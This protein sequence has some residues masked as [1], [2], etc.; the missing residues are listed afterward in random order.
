[1]YAAH[2]KLIAAV[3][4][5]TTVTIAGED[6]AKAEA[7]D[8]V[9]T[10]CSD[11]ASFSGETIEF[12]KGRFRHW[13]Y[14]DVIVAGAK[15]PKYPLEGEYKVEGKKLILSNDE[16]YTKEWTIDTVNGHNVLWRDDGLKLWNEEKRIH[17]YAVL[18]RTGD[19]WSGRIYHS[20][21]P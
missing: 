12:A 16:D 20:A 14:T 4:I 6:V 17:P 21:H 7:V 11:V 10:M 19:A 5:I 13:F 18:I 3:A 2:V 15:K 1:M 9:Y 8:G